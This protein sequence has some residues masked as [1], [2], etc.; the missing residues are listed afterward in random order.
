MG[1]S[2]SSKGRRLALLAGVLALVSLAVAAPALRD[3]I[4]IWFKLREDFESLRGG[5]Y[6][7]RGTWTL[8]TRV[9]GF[10]ISVS[11]FNVTIDGDSSYH[12]ILTVRRNDAPESSYPR[13]IFDDPRF[14]IPTVEQWI[15][16]KQSGNIHKNAI[17]NYHQ[18]LGRVRNYANSCMG[19]I[20]YNIR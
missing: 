2:S 16:A 7:H 5:M 10:L 17:C 15:Q 11:P 6:R 19:R 12:V 4:K 1:M 13:D 20:V 14:S 9:D 8:F 3:E 18:G